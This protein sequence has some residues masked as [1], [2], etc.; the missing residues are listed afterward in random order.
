MTSMNYFHFLKL[1][2][3]EWRDNRGRTI[4]S[5]V[6]ALWQLNIELFSK[7]FSGLLDFSR[8]DEEIEKKFLTKFLDWV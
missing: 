4:S 7:H 8:I 1:L 5:L 3:Q 6:F 2:P